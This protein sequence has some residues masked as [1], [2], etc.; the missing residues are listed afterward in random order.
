MRKRYA[1]P[2]I[3]IF[4][5]MIGINFLDMFLPDDIITQPQTTPETKTPTLNQQYSEE[6]FEEYTYQEF[7]DAVKSGEIDPNTLPDELRN[8]YQFII[9]NP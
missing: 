2:I 5:G 9:N 7:V 4:L 8:T 6:H 1:I 3:T